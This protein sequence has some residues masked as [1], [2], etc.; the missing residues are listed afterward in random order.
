M[1]KYKFTKCLPRKVNNKLSIK[2]K[3]FM[4]LCCYS[5]TVNHHTIVVTKHEGKI[6]T[7]L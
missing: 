2:G 5:N 7:V 1:Y 4:I 3:I 6:I